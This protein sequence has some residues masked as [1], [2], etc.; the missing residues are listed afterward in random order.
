M[1]RRRRRDVALNDAVDSL[2]WLAGCR[3]GKPAQTNQAHSELYARLETG[4]ARI[5]DG[6]GMCTEGEAREALL[7]S[8]AGYEPPGDNANLA[9]YREELVSLPEDVHD[10]PLINNV[11][12]ASTRKWLEE[13]VG[14]F[15]LS[16]EDV[17]A[18]DLRQGPAGAYMDPVLCSSPKK[19]AKLLRRLSQIGLISYCRRPVAVGGLF[20][21]KKK[22]GLIRMIYDSR[23]SNR[24]FARP[25]GVEL[26]SSEAFFRDG[27]GH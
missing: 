24:F 23:R 2:N 17:G 12:S 6:R 18:A 9:S 20:F 11:L 16:E 13:D 14:E 1:L 7:R 8:S 21:V 4:I 5:D 26:A 15:V 10:A 19:Y 3:E 25:P 22:G 27:G